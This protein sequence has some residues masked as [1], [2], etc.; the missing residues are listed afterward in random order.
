MRVNHVATWT[1]KKSISRKIRTATSTVNRVNSSIQL[2]YTALRRKK[3]KS[4]SPLWKRITYFPCT[5]LS[6]V[7]LDLRL[8]KTRCSQNPHNKDSGGSR[9]WAK[10]GGGD[11]PKAP[12]LDSPL[13][14]RHFYWRLA[15]NKRRLVEN[16]RRLVENKRRLAE[17]KRRL[18]E[19][20]CT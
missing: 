10:E 6:P 1:C 4:V 7:S 11:P 12:P 15:E 14:D 17:N 16:K 2:G 19:N 3:L 8:T 9:P 18:V 20:K 5:L 13:K